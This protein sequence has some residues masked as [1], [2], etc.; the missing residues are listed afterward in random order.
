MLG[1]HGYSKDHRPDLHQMILAVVL[2]GDGRP[3]CSEMWPG[4]TADVAGLMP[5]V[6]RLQQRFAI[7]HVCI[8]ADRGM[9]S[10]ETLAQLEARKLFYIL[11]ARERSDKLVREVVLSDPAPFVPLTMTRRRRTY[12][13]G[14]R[15]RRGEVSTATRSLAGLAV[16]VPAS[17]ETTG[18]FIAKVPNPAHPAAMTKRATATIAETVSRPS[19]A[20]TTR[21]AAT[22]TNK[23]ASA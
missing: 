19:G 13:A 12:A 1:R 18:V 6:D 3:V 2:D 15:G 16:S 8:V 23:E 7:A 17:A 10:T 14:L 4:N 5:I 9:I 11:G 21:S 20:K 22:T